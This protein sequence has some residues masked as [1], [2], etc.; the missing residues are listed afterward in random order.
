MQDHSLCPVCE[1]AGSLSTFDVANDV[2]WGEQAPRY[3]KSLAAI[4]QSQNCPFCRLVLHVLQTAIEGIISEHE[5]DVLLGS[6]TIARALRSMRADLYD[7][8]LFDEKGAQVATAQP[9]SSSSM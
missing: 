4:Q 9:C 8:K 6:T 7:A 2:H 5:L 3:L 1:A